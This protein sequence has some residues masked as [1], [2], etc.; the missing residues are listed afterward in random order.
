MRIHYYWIVLV[1]LIS[2]IG[3]NAS[4]IPEN[5][6]EKNARNISGTVYYYNTPLA[7][8]RV[9]LATQSGSPID[10]YFIGDAYDVTTDSNGEY[11]IY[12]DQLNPGDY[13]IYF[14]TSDANYNTWNGSPISLDENIFSTTKNGYMKKKVTMLSPA[15][16]AIGVSLNPTLDWEDYSDA[17]NYLCAVYND[18]TG[19]TISYQTFLTDSHYTLT[20]SLETNTQYEWFVYAYASNGVG[21]AYNTFYFQTMQ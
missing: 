2:I 9:F 18:Q 5:A 17:T 11:T 16:Q 21:V 10:T 3:C 12:V 20:T 15:N 13:Y 8:V 14:V 4:R 1:L 6:N 19:E 7:N